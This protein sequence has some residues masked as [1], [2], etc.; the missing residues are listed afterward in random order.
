MGQ[1]KT[2]GP[3]GASRVRRQTSNIDAGPCT[4]GNGVELRRDRQGQSQRVKAGQGVKNNFR[5]LF[6]CDPLRLAFPTIAVVT[7]S[8]RPLWE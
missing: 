3:A 2:Q 6:A 4:R 7:F 1:G 5:F 8:Q